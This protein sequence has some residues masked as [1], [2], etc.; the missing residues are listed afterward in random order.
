MWNHE[1]STL[2]RQSDGRFRAL[3]LSYFL[4]AGAE[5]RADIVLRGSTAGAA[6]ELGDGASAVLGGWAALDPG[7]RPRLAEIEDCA[8]FTEPSL[9]THGGVDYLAVNCVMLVGGVR[10]LSL[11]KVHLL[12]FGDTSFEYVGALLDA[13]DAAQVG[14]VRIEQVDLAHTHDGRVILLATPITTD[15]LMFH[16]GCRIFEVTDPSRAELLR[17]DA[18]EL[19][20]LA[21]V[22]AE[23]T[24]PGSGQCTYEPDNELG[25]VIGATLY[26]ASVDPPSLP[27]RIYATR[28]H[29]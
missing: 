3:W 22:T 18:G 25:V 26:D 16:R 10:E 2:A 27:W 21:E 20:V 1:V 4:R 19:V 5:E 15:A 6:E 12:R 8:A 7:S 29:P 24:G 23:A 17:N 14:A 11:E 13:T 9:F 28:Y